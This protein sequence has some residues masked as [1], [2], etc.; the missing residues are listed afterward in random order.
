MQA[1]A[2]ACAAIRAVTVAEG[3]RL[4]MS[5]MLHPVGVDATSSSGMLEREAW[6]L[7]LQYSQRLGTSES[8]TPHV[9]HWYSSWGPKSGLHRLCISF[10]ANL[11]TSAMPAWSLQQEPCATGKFHCITSLITMSFFV[12]SCVCARPS[13]AR[14]AGWGGP[15]CA[16]AAGG[17]PA[18][19]WP[20]LRE[21]PVRVAEE[22]GPSR[23]AE[24]R[25]SR[26]LRA[27]LGGGEPAPSWPRLSSSP[28]GGAAPAAEPRSGGTGSSEPG[29]SQDAASSWTWAM[30]GHSSGAK[31]SARL[32]SARHSACRG[33]SSFQMRAGRAPFLAMSTTACLLMP[34]S[35]FRQAM[36]MCA[37]RPKE[38]TSAL[39][40]GCVWGPRQSTS[41]AIQS[42]VP[43]SGLALLVRSLERPKS[44]NFALGTSASTRMF[45]PFKSPWA[46]RGCCA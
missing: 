14:A 4:R 26:K 34:S 41:G 22:A 25:S 30:L 5:M 20:A 38:K 9:S 39:G 46:M 29:S 45:E 43:P 33:R 18:S 3:Q 12:A 15:S 35:G 10:P 19:S 44:N 2:L 31:V 8:S 21:G 16:P 24:L 28:A 27:L 32:Q 7:L 40:I 11:R 42:T 1:G 23:R 6:E 37:T 17:A 13:S 36:I